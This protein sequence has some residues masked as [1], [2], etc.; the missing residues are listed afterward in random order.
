MRFLARTLFGICLV[1][2]RV[3]LKSE[4]KI[5]DVGRLR[6]SAKILLL[7]YFKST[8]KTALMNNPMTMEKMIKA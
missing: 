7:I 4:S 5:I 2:T 8:Q 1:T 6:G 3:F